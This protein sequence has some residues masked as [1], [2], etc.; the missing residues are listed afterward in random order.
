MSVARRSP[1]NGVSVVI[2]TYNRADLV[3]RALQSVFA[4]TR[5]VDEVLLVDDGSTDDTEAR[6]RNAYGDRVRY[7]RQSNAGVSVARNLGLREARG[8]YIAFLDSDDLWMPDKTR[9]QLQF[10]ERHPDYGLVLCDV[11]RV[12]ADGRPIDILHRRAALPLDGRIVSNVLRNPTLVPA[13]AMIRREVYET[14]GGFDETLRTAEDLDFHLRVALE[15]PIGV[16]EQPLV[17]A[18]RCHGGLSSASSAYDDYVEVYRRFVARCRG[19]LPEAELDRAMATAYLRSALG[20]AQEARW[21]AAAQACGRA[22][23]TSPTVSTARQTMKLIPAVL[24][25]LSRSLRPR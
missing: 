7:L 15:W 2:P 11:E 22:W 12:T 23:V 21:R 1:A 19:I 24:G 14:V 3:M 17:R 10:L 4:Q 5:P 9:Q 20:A 8:E 16:V 25:S 13:S 18:I 6:V